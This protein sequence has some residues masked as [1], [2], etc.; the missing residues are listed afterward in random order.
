[1][2]IVALNVVVLVGGV[3]G[4]KLVHGLAQ[5][6]PPGQLTA[7]VNTGDDF[8]HHGLR[9]CPDLDTVMYTL[10][11]IVDRSQGWGV[12]EDTT[13]MLGALRRYGEDTWFRLGDQDMATHLLRSEWLRAGQTLTT[14]T[15][16]L[17]ARL[18]VEQRVL[19]MTDDPVATIVD[20]VEHGEIGF[21]EYFVRRRWQPT[22]RGLHLGGVETAR[23]T[24]AVAAAVGEADVIL[25]GPSN[26]WLSIMPVLAVPGMRAALQTN[27]G[28]R[29]AITP[30]IRGEAVKGP[31]SKLMAEL[32]YIPAAE[33][34]A[35][36]YGDLIDGF[37]YDM[38]DDAFSMPTVQTI[39]LDTLMR[40]EADRVRLAQH[41]LDWAAT[42]APV[43]RA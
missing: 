38:R 43:R 7:V 27:A 31:A 2:Y 3:G 5:I 4:A 23:M 14:I 25:L 10:A 39:A 11:G 6:L 1:V 17:C 29:I 35:R 28:P 19:P 32:G 20:T 8:W 26:P 40:S 9:V 36:Y 13:Q 41:V 30:I 12:A 15:E 34:V 18:G 24:A 33:S 37:V 21:Q 22:V 16:T 42:L